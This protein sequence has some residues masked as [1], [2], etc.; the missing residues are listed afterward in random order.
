[1]PITPKVKCLCETMWHPDLKKVSHDKVAWVC[2][3]CG[4]T[5][6]WASGQD[7]AAIAWDRKFEGAKGKNTPE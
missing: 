1:M 2:P 7:S 3:V 6:P 5:G 4:L